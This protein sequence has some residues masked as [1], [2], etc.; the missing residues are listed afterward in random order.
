MQVIVGTARVSK[1]S[2]TQFLALVVVA[3]S[4]GASSCHRAGPVTYHLPPAL[5]AS[6]SPTQL[7]P[8]ERYADTFCT[9]LAKEFANQ[10]WMECKE[11]LR[12]LRPSSTVPLEEDFSGWTLL[13]IGGFGA[14]CLE[15]KL[16]AFEDAGD[17]LSSVHKMESLHVPVG[18]FDTSEH[19]AERIR[20]FVTKQ[21]ESKKFIV[22]AHSKGA[23][24]TLVALATFPKELE[25]V[26]AV[27]TIAG[28]VGGSWLVDRLE[29]L[30][31]K[32]QSTMELPCSPPTAR[33][34]KTAIDSL[35]RAERYKF[36][37]EHDA[38]AARAYSISAVSSD[39]QTSKILRGLWRRLEPHSLEQDS[40]IVEGESVVPWGTFL[41]RA[42]GDHWAVA[43]PFDG[44]P[45]VRPKALKVI[46]KN[47]F[48]RPALVEA[49]VRIAIADLAT[50]SR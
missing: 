46:D 2:L 16:T 41:G 49:A 38:S 43:M 44:N 19:N 37:A 1:S 42:L 13:R 21:P 18:G 31:A 5:S 25:R 40:H 34:G 4:F 14:Q 17:H 30:N 22:V 27:I 9:I 35:K 36:V 8:S 10:S 29:R 28:A 12:M 15:S 50:T 48:P 11:Y 32:L 7:R 45:K 23:A 24:D 3:A 47:R 39:A 33:A 26:K 6:F 20:D